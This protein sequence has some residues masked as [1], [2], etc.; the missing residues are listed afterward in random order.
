ME[1]FVSLAQARKRAK[2]GDLAQL[3][4]KIRKTGGMRMIK[5]AFIGNQGRTV[6]VR[7]AGTVMASRSKYTGSKYA[8]QIRAVSTVDVP[9]MFN[10]KRINSKVV[11]AMKDKFPVIFQR[12]AAYY[13]S[14]FKP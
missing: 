13:T 5:G 9:G 3:R 1:R 11:A 2:A 12:E 4:F 14:K 7:V 10:T 6:F 8:E